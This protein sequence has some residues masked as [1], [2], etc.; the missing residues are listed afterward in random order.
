MYKVVITGGRTWLFN[1]KSGN[2]F[3][4]SQSPEF[5]KRGE[6]LLKILEHLKIYNQPII[7]VGDASGVDYM[8][9]IVCNYIGISFIEYKADWDKHGKSAGP[10][11]NQEMIDQEPDL[12]LAFPGGRGTADCVRRAKKAKIKVIELKGP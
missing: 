2:F 4:C 10:I 8:T 7:L 9:K 6:Y 12:V 3:H 5:N 1:A 11:R